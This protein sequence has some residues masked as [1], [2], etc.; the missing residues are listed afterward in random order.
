MNLQMAWMTESQYCANTVWRC[1]VQSYQIT[2]SNIDASVDNRRIGTV[3]RVLKLI[4]GQR[5]RER[6]K[7]HL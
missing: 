4:Q 7:V 2:D 1:T 3:T 6:C 5:I